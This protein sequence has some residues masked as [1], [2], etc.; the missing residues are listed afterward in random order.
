MR[1]P[2]ISTPCA[3]RPPQIPRRR[4]A[5]STRC[6]P[7]AVPRNGEQV[8]N[9]FFAIGPDPPGS[10]FVPWMIMSSEVTNPPEESDEPQVASGGVAQDINWMD[11]RDHLATA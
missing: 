6:E 11:F 8:A 9:T 2:A 1:W 10:D 4:K 7:D 3:G 5:K